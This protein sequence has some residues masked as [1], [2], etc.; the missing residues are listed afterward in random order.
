VKP[1]YQMYICNIDITNHCTTGCIYC[2]RFIRHLRPDHRYHMSLDGFRKALES[3][4]D[5]PGKI[6]I[7]GGEPTLHPQ[8]AEICE[9]IQH[10]FPRPQKIREYQLFTSCGP[11][12]LEFKR[13][14]RGT[15]G[16]VH[17]NPHDEGQRDICL[18]QPS[19][20]AIGE[21]IADPEIRER[22]IDNC[23]VQK[24]WAPGINSKGAFFCEIAG[25]MDVV[26]NGPG[27]Y[28]IEPGWW[29]KE[30]KDFEDQRK[31]YCHKCGMAIPLNRQVL[32]NGKE[33]ITPK[34]L[35][36][37]KQHHLPR[38]SDVDVEVFIGQLTSGNLKENSKTW[39]PGN[40]RQD[41]RKDKW[42]K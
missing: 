19:L 3:L 27:G 41:L 5:W 42:E 17:E 35:A 32:K 24:T 13:L 37:F 10:E 4:V 40:Y 31:R 1:I 34:L 16:C 7:G 22:L 23:W 26:L 33:K 36:E 9:I 21:V 11:R 2:S 25:G 18:H 6:G 8:F 12:Y 28:P 20:V 30:P 38:T 39:D 15:F 29:R 14:C